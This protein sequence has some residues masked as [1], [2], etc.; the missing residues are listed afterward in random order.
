MLDEVVVV[1]WRWRSMESNTKHPWITTT[2]AVVFG[3]SPGVD[4]R[5][6]NPEY[7]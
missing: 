6:I 2:L 4:S 3:A 5:V 7:N 1:I